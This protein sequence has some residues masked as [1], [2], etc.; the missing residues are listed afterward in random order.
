MIRNSRGWLFEIGVS[1]QIWW[2]IL[3]EHNWGI[4]SAHIKFIYYNT[5]VIH[6]LIMLWGHAL[7]GAYTILKLHV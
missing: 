2:N 6:Y 1:Y 4:P 3:R 7:T 5:Y